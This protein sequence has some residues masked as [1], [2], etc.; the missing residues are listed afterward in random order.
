MKLSH[1]ILMNGMMKPQGFGADSM[2]S[3]DAPCAL[4]GAL[5]TVGVQVTVEASY[6][7]LYDIWPWIEQ[8]H[9][10]PACRVYKSKALHIIYHLNDQHEWTRAQI[11][12]FVATIEPTDCPEVDSTE[13]TISELETSLSS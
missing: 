7:K 2:Y 4:G 8:Q 10:C 1:A 11:A 12:E 5:Q 6:S 13:A 3:K 9:N